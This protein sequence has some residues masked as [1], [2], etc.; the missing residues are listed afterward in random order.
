MWRTPVRYA[1][2]TSEDAYEGAYSTS[3]IALIKLKWEGAAISRGRGVKSFL[4]YEGPA[5]GFFFY[6][7][8]AIS[9]PQE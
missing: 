9:T 1:M 5:Y 4:A 6:E 8:F 3:D 7:Q 2:I